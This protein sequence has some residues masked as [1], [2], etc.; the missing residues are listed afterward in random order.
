MAL[1][2]FVPRILTFVIV[3]GEYPW[4]IIDFKLFFE[5]SDV[6]AWKAFLL[7]QAVSVWTLKGLLR[8]QIK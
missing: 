7:E 5:N 1:W 6:S 8:S 3:R 2:G 4:D